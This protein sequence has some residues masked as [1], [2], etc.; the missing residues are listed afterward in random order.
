MWLY[1]IY[2]Q[3]LM[4]VLFVGC[5]LA[6]ELAVKIV[7]CVLPP[8]PI[9]EQI[10]LCFQSGHLPMEQA[11]FYLRF[12]WDPHIGGKINFCLNLKAINASLSTL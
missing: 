8:S 10:H 7:H 9:S 11:W 12:A 1:A 5:L 3:S 2:S 6:T 4:I